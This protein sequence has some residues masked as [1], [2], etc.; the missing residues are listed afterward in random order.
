MPAVTAETATLVAGVALIVGL[1]ALLLALWLV[2]RTR[3]LARQSAFRPEMPADLQRKVEAEVIRLDALIRQ[4]EDIRGRL[5]TIEGQAGS[6]LQRIGIV[7]FNPFEDTGGQQSFVVALLDAHSSGFL[8][9]SH[10]SRQQTRVYM[11]QVTEGR[12][13]TQ[14]S[15]EETEALRQAG[16]AA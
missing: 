11:K 6:A 9:S 10:H 14:L 2:S 15:E 12:T 3:G 4:V 1:L 5:P 16:V 7:R 8:I 13:E